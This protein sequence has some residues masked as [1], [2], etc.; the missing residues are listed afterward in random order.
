M[1]HRDLVWRSLGVC[2][3]CSAGLVG[4]V[5]QPGT[6]S[7]RGLI[8]FCLAISGVVLIVQGKRVPAALRV[9]RSRHRALPQTISE[10]RRRG[11]ASRNS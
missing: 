11:S 2:A 8:A 6:E 9:E 7:V 10:R 3:L 5:N 1:T 4:F